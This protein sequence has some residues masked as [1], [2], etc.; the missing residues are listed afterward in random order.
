MISRFS[1]FLF[2]CLTACSGSLP[3]PSQTVPPEESWVDVPYPPPAAL[4]E[5]VTEAPE[6][7]AVW[8]DGGWVWRG[9]YYVWERGGWVV[10]ARNLR[11]SPWRVRYL[12]GGQAQFARSQWIDEHGERVRPLVPQKAAAIPPNEVTAEFQTGR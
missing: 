3:L 1:A 11:F 7:R 10:P 2:G 4:T 6:P 12:P 8:M 9:R 5:L